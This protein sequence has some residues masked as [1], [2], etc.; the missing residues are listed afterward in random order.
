MIL[1]SCFCA[2]I[3]L[4]GG[5]TEIN[6]RVVTVSAQPTPDVQI[7]LISASDTFFTQTDKSGSYR[8]PSSVPFGTYTLQGIKDSLAFIVF[9]LLYSQ[10]FSARTDTLWKT[11]SIRGIAALNNKA[12]KA[13]I[14]FYIPG[15]SF[16][17]ISDDEGRAVIAYVPAGTYPVTFAYPEYLPARD[18]VMVRAG[19]TTEVGPVLLYRDPTIP[20]TLLVPQ[21][22]HGKYDSLTGVIRLSWRSVSE[23]AIGYVVAIRNPR[24][25]KSPL[26]KIDKYIS[27]TVFYDTLFQQDFGDTVPVEHRS[28]QVAAVDS[29]FTI[30][31]ACPPVTFDVEKPVYPLPPA[32]D[33]VK[34]NHEGVIALWG[35]T[36]RLRWVDSMIIYRVI[37]KG[38]KTRVAAVPAAGRFA[39]HDTVSDIPLEG[40]SLLPIT[41]TFYSRTTGG[42]ASSPTVA[43]INI[44]NP[45]AVYHLAAPSLPEGPFTI[46]PGRYLY[47]FRECASPVPHDTTEYRIIVRDSISGSIRATAWYDSPYIEV[48]FDSAGHYYMFSQVRS[49]RIPCVQSLLSNSV[50]IDV[51]LVH[52]AG[53]PSTPD[54]Q[55]TT[56]INFSNTY[57]LSGVPACNHQHEV[58]VQFVYTYQH[59]TVH[60]A[61]AWSKQTKIELL[62]EHPGTAFL[63]AHAR[64]RVDTTIISVWSDARII[65]ISR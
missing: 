39:Y 49:E 57:T 15:T 54:G 36:P 4:T 40:D 16:H 43:K 11:G 34:D 8:F 64:C 45:N 12:K 27:D 19:M 7:M 29:N 1:V 23:R 10:N 24:I 22:L 9:D 33:S 14:N 35:S 48:T 58:E 3:S 32:V 38:A 25:D 51:F 26:T 65:T 61:S 42:V 28:Y 21:D 60:F 63:R 52:A 20:F 18:T 41:Y 6:G 47:S 46:Q 17:A 53:K 56:K 13:G 44:Y 2:K 50:A 37:D 30:G 31:Q 62:W 5:G 59:D 55:I